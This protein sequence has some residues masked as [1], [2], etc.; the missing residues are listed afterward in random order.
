MYRR[1]NQGFTWKHKRV[2]HIY[3]R[4]K[5]KMRIKPRRH[6]NRDKP[7]ALS[8][9]TAINKVQSMDFMSDSLSNRKRILT[10]NV[11]DDYNREGVTIEVGLSLPSGSVIIALDEA[12]E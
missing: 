8:V 5:L 11:I 4:L 6:I 3:R 10:F 12:I 1:N 9:P 7:N 2:D